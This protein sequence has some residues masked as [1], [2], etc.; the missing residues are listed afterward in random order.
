MKK[1]TLSGG[2]CTAF[3][4]LAACLWGTT[5][6]FVRHLGDVGLGTMT[7]CVLR[8]AVAL[9][10]MLVLA[11]C[12]DPK[13]LR[14]RLRDLWCFFGTG[15][16]SMLFFNYCYFRTIEESSMAVAATMLYTAPVFVLILSA[17]LFRE[18]ITRRKVLALVLAVVGCV[19]VSGII[20]GGSLNGTGVLLGLGA[21]FGYGLYSI[22]TRFALNRGYSSVTISVYTFLFATLGGLP[23]MGWGQL[24]AAH[25]TGGVG[26][27][28][29][30]ALYALVTTVLPYL[31]YNWGL[32]RVE[33][34]K[35]AVI[36][37]VEP[38]VAALLGFVSPY[39][40][41]PGP[42][43]FVGILLVLGAVVLLNVRGKRNDAETL[44]G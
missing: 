16:L 2:V 6:L 39:H 44:R 34:S 17:L 18:H 30:L 21:G 1:L 22:F 24:S 23:L 3:V 5:G 43:E 10:M 42:M 9:A 11:L 20:T 19:L 29:F 35:A 25:G 7:I 28:L 14:V 8:S 36:A 37:S 4:V 33:N 41:V 26:L 32:I 38:V 15:V 12:I 13:L 31:F 27:W 40:E